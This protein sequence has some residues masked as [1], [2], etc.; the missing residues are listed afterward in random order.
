MSAWH[1]LS[2]RSS[3]CSTGMANAA[4]LPVPEWAWAI[5]SWP[6]SKGTMARCWMA[7]G[8]SKLSN[9]KPWAYMPR[10]RSSRKSMSSKVSA[11]FRTPSVTKPESSAAAPTWGWD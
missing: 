2:D 3:F 9:K 5:V 4:V 10:S 6:S 1:W 7:V 8:F 11:I